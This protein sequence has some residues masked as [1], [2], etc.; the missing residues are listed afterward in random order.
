[1]SNEGEIFMRAALIDRKGSLEHALK[2]CR[3]FIAFRFRSN[4]PLR[5]HA[6]SV[7][8]AALR[9]GM[10]QLWSHGKTPVLLYD[11]ERLQVRSDGMEIED[12]QKMGCFLIEC[13]LYNDSAFVNVPSSEGRHLAPKRS[14]DGKIIL[15]IDA[16]GFSLSNL[17]R[18]SLNDIRRGLDMWRT[19]PLDPPQIFIVRPSRVM[20]PLLWTARALLAPHFKD[21]IVIV[22]SRF[23]RLHA[24]VELSSLPLS[25][26][27]SS[28]RDWDA[29]VKACSLRDAHVRISSGE[30]H[31]SF[32]KEIQTSSH[33]SDCFFS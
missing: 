26:G 14:W 25:L 12:Y 15:V 11:Y 24:H 19:F 1:M 5:F 30:M 29:H 2:L 8:P 32:S 7:A 17:L 18:F 28:D 16:H 10:H 23:Q 31:P 4:W 13:L 22:D 9:S 33:G 3:N 21:R 27:G 20:K 6:E